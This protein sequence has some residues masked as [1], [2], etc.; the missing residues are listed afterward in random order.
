[1]RSLC[2]AWISIQTPIMYVA[3]LIA[4]GYRNLDGE[5]PLCHPLAVLFGE[6]NAGKSNVVDGLR[7]V[8]EAEAGRERRAG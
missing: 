7:T 6:N 2:A 8:L 1:M 5:Y 4:S 3:A